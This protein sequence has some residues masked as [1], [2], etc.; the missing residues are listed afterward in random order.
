MFQTIQ[1]CH[2]KTINGQLPLDSSRTFTAKSYIVILSL[3]F[4]EMQVGHRYTP[5]EETSMWS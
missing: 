3:H 2:T 4:L 1:V 5:T